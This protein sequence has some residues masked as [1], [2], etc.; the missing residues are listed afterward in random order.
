M[1][2]RAAGNEPGE[3]ASNPRRAA[4]APIMTL[5]TN[6][7][8]EI[9]KG[10]DANI[11]DRIAA[12]CVVFLVIA[13]AFTFSPAAPYP[14]ALQ[15]HAAALAGIVL[16]IIVGF[17]ASAGR[18]FPVPPLAQGTLAIAGAFF[19]SALLC[20]FVAIGYSPARAFSAAACAA[21]LV[22]VAAAARSAARAHLGNVLLYSMCASGFVIITIGLLEA[23]G[24]DPLST[25]GFYNSQMSPVATFGNPDA[26]V[27]FV[28]PVTAVAAALACARGGASRIILIIVA[29]GGAAYLGRLGV[30]FGAAAFAAG[31]AAALIL[32]IRRVAAS[33]AS[34]K[35]A[36]QPTIISL[37]IPAVVFIIFF[38]S[39]PRESEPAPPASAPAASAAHWP[40]PASLEVRLRVW[41]SCI[42][43]IRAFAPFGTAVGNF[44]IPFAGYRDPREIAISSN[45]RRDPAETTVDSAHN[46]PLQ[47]ITEAGAL[48][49]VALGAFA[50]ALFKFSRRGALRATPNTVA[51]ASGLAALF[52]CS[53]FHSPFYEQPSAAIAG[54]ILLG[55][56][57]AADN[58]TPER[59]GGA[60]GRM[61]GVVLL[62]CA[63]WAAIV[64][65]GAAAADI[66][67]IAE[68]M[69]PQ[70]GGGRLLKA[71]E[72]NTTDEHIPLALAEK[73]QKNGE[74]SAAIAAYA[75]ALDRR[76]FLVECLIQSG[77]LLAKMG[78]F[79]EASNAFESCMA[80]DPEHPALAY[81]RA[82]AAR[83][84]DDDLSAIARLKEAVRF[85]TDPGIVRQWGVWF[86]EGKNYKKARPYLDAWAAEH[87]ADGDTW[88]MLGNISLKLNDRAS[89]EIE[90]AKAH[91]IY[92]LDYLQKGNLESAARSS[93]Q[94]RRWAAAG[95]AG[96]DILDA[97]I[98]YADGKFEDAR[99][100]LKHAA[101][102]NLTIAA[103]ELETA[104]YSKMLADPAFGAAARALIVK[105]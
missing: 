29:T 30:L 78:K 53:L 98:A 26:V 34:V 6:A 67:I 24:F 44:S 103:S 42:Q 102:S 19:A 101:E 87:P 10:R 62:L 35:S 89:A 17:C 54:F 50:V 90:F 12:G 104:E 13:G 4:A 22:I 9:P 72:Y 68:R 94:Y 23:A 93:R 38:L 88:S 70:P 27:D 2:A 46:E 15:Q 20:K 61:I 52:I 5:A 14:L 51:A 82:C 85:G 86:N 71:V 96:P 105:N 48:G 3:G 69:D 31:I 25:A 60:T 74:W 18:G 37:L 49:I 36:V 47:F 33:G 75:N 28:A 8:F 65:G 97:A 79:K 84:L 21:G 64:S 76:P 83:D 56:A 100:A 58:G 91:R 41:G 39:R 16:F 43:V 55:I 45:Y 63:P 99:A 40:V 32:T 73:L 66:Y 80:F 11:Y 92:A 81:N 95:S 57:G 7:K 1:N 59:V 77:T